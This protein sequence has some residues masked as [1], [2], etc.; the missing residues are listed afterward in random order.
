MSTWRRSWSNVARNR[1]V[2]R[3]WPE[4]HVIDYSCCIITVWGHQR[5]FLWWATY[6]RLVRSVR[7]SRYLG[8][9]NDLRVPRQLYLCWGCPTIWEYPCRWVSALHD[10][11]LGQISLLSELYVMIPYLDR[12]TVTGFHDAG[13]I[14]HWV[15]N[16]TGLF[17]RIR[18]N[19]LSWSIRGGLWKTVPM[20]WPI[21]CDETEYPRPRISSWID[22]PIP[23]KGRPGPHD[24]MP[25]ANAS[26]D[27]LTSSR[28]CS[29]CSMGVSTVRE[30][31]TCAQ[32]APRHQQERFQMCLHD[33]LQEKL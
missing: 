22:F 16:K 19:S 32:D 31:T 28:P 3:T 9:T 15:R 12:E 29:S 30:D 13:F 7:N 21:N 20:P 17:G 8:I 33:S 11:R 23:L 10:A 25:T 1:T 24:W 2:V 27:I 5:H 4:K 14:V 18:L 6:V 26:L